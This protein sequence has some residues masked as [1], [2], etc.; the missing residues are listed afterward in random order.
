MVI[1]AFAVIINLEERRKYQM[2]KFSKIIAGVIAA[3]TMVSAT[4]VISSAVDYGNT[5]SYKEPDKVTEE[6]GA[7]DATPTEIVTDDVITEAIKN[8]A[9]VYITSDAVVKEDAIG[10]IAKSDVPVTFEADDYSIT[11]DPAL[12]EEVGA[13]DLSMDIAVSDSDVE[14]DGVAVP[15]G[16]IVIAPAQ[17]GAFGMTLKVTISA[18]TVEDLDTDNISLYY[19]DDDG[20]VTK[21]DS[22]IEVNADGSVSISISHAS[23]YVVSDVDLTADEEDDDE[24]D[25]TIDDDDDVVEIDDDADSEVDAVVTEKDESNPHTGVALFGTAALTAV[26]AAVMTATAKKR[27]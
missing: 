23:K 9:V 21:L 15:A 26:S 11:I 13:I 6:S 8:D 7:T 14:V 27:K 22:D 19:I 1:P 24:D 25:A 5:P 16:A 10:A 3:T 20:N 18:A 12:I 2:K 4:T 17:K